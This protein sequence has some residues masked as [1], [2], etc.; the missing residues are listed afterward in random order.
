MRPVPLQ[1]L[2]V[3]F[4]EVEG[5]IGAKIA[6]GTKAGEAS[7]S[8]SSQSASASVVVVVVRFIFMF[9]LSHTI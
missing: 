5:E 9:Y 3:D 1:R 8:A 7:K 2:Q 4:L 6:T